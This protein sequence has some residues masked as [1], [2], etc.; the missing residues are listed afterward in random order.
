MRRDGYLPLSAH[1]ESGERFC[2]LLFKKG[3]SEVK[4]FIKLC[5]GLIRSSSGNNL[6]MIAGFATGFGYYFRN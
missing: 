6:F 4:D 2:V 1:C 5:F 3:Y